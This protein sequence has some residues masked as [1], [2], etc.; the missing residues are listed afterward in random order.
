MNSS[1]KFSLLNQNSCGQGTYENILNE[2][3]YNIVYSFGYEY[4][5][6]TNTGQPDGTY[7]LWHTFK[8]KDSNDHCIGFY[9]GEESGNTCV[10]I[11]SGRKY[12]FTSKDH[13]VNH[14]RYK[15]FKYKL[16]IN[17]ILYGYKAKEQS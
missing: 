1:T 17:Y 14:L 3:L 13:L 6:S 7:K 4:S 9:M 15:R 8:H 10:R 2:P 16:V 5:H 12:P 11:G